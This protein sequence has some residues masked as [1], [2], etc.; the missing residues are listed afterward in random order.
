MTVPPLRELRADIRPNVL[1]LLAEHRITLNAATPFVLG[2]A[3]AEWIQAQDWPGNYAQL[4]SVL[5]T[6]ARASGAAEI[7]VAALEAGLR[8]SASEMATKPTATPVAAVA[9]PAKPAPVSNHA[10]RRRASG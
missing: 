4:S 3:G 7:E 2:D 8:Q 9:A 6:A 5:L 10:S 1:Q